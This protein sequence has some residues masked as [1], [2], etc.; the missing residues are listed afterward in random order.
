MYNPQAISFDIQSRDPFAV[1]LPGKSWDPVGKYELLQWTG[2]R[3]AEGTDVY[4]ADLVFIHSE[5]YF[6]HWNEDF[7]SFELKAWRGS[8]QRDMSMV[9]SGKV[10]GNT[11]ET[12]N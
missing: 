9:T 1:S 8:S 12:E 2:L 10:I 6:V 3:D 5:I 7:A 4:E 11:Y